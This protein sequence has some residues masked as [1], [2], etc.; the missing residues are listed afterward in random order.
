M[1]EKGTF[2]DFKGWRFTAPFRCICCGRK[3]DVRQF[4]FGRS[5]GICDTG[6]CVHPN[7]MHGMPIRCYSGPRELIDPND[8]HFL[9]EDRWVNPPSGF[10]GEGE[11]PFP[12]KL[13]IF[14]QFG[15]P[16]P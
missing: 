16:T 1:D 14:E 11:D 9:A 10:D 8:S 6:K 3:I 15:L 13:T 5:C 12:K 4:C 2:V 7:S